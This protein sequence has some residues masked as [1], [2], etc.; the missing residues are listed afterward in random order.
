M[1]QY[2]NN[3]THSVHRLWSE[4]VLYVMVVPV[5][6]RMPQAHALSYIF[7]IFIMLCVGIK[8][9]KCEKIRA[10][11]RVALFLFSI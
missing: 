5:E 9:N 1:R 4:L 8:V 7:V 10:I 6:V 11:D 3:L 2:E